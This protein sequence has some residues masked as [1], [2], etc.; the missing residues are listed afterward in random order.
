MKLAG[1]RDD[2]W[3]AVRGI[4]RRPAYG[5]VAS[6]TVAMAIGAAVSIFSV[7]NGV[8]LRPADLPDPDQLVV[9]WA[10]QEDGAESRPLSARDFRAINEQIDLLEHVAGRWVETASLLSGDAPEAITLSSVSEQYF[11]V[12]GLDPLVGRFPDANDPNQ[13]LM[14]EGLWVRRFGRDPNIVG[15]SIRVGSGTYAV[16]GIL[17]SNPDP[18]IPTVGGIVEDVD[19]WRPIPPE[20]LELDW[21]ISFLRVVGRM[22]NGTA[23]LQLNEAFEPFAAALNPVAGRAPGEVGFQATALLDEIVAGV[24]PTLV[25]LLAAA[26]L[27]LVT[28]CVNVAQLTAARA[29]TR[30]QTWALR[31]VLGA[32]RWRLARIAIL[33]SFLVAIAGGGGGVWLAEISIRLL[34][35][36]PYLELP[37][38]EQVSIDVPVLIFA[39]VATSLSVLLFGLLP[40]LRAARSAVSSHWTGSGARVTRRRGDRALVVGEV[41]GSTVLLVG[42]GLLLLTYSAAS[43]ADPGWEAEGVTTVLITPS[44]GENIEEQ[45]AVMAEI[46][47]ALQGLPGVSAAGMANRMPL[48]GGIY[49]G[50]WATRANFGG[51]GPDRAADIRFVTPGF[52]DAMGI[53]VLEGRSF[54]SADDRRA[55]VIDAH[56][57]REAFGDS[58]PLGREIWTGVFGID[59]WGTVVGVVE[60]A[61]HESVL[62]DALPTIYFRGIARAGGASAWRAAIRSSAPPGDVVARLRTDLA[63]VDDGA[64]ISDVRT[65]S[66][67]V[68]EALSAQR[69]S[70]LLLTGFAA[71]SLITTIIGLYSLLALRVEERKRDFGVRQALGATPAR[72]LGTVVGEGAVLGLAGLALGGVLSVALGRWVESLLFGVRP[73][74]LRVL[75]VTA[76]VVSIVVLLSSAVPALRTTRIDPAAV[77]NGDD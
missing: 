59:G 61:R 14:S 51:G 25:V 60:H 37:R 56:M 20:W 23:V 77:L 73:N 64:T 40:A 34:R 75:T 62:A 55:V 42:T 74:D 1:W 21:D 33:E 18:N 71:A 3:A 39:A 41:A 7:V 50:T 19:L 31:A 69:L 5:A 12:L 45:R 38:L 24:R 16:T 17:A 43:R 32:S 26:M 47:R 27:L 15:R 63:E 46:D 67:R 65:M 70:S 35:S 8:L 11:D 9:I 2:A 30:S 4:A 54:E 44:R 76:L 28:A 72:L 13:V 22:R 36:M 52:F 68:S 57:A 66:E 53:G 58:D 48:M 29:R 49:D 10:Q 6:L